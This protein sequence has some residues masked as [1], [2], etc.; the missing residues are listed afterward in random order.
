[1]EG[2]YRCNSCDTNFSSRS[3][4]TG[5]LDAVHL[6]DS[7]D[8]FLCNKRISSKNNLSRHLKEVSGMGTTN[9]IIYMGGLIQDNIHV[10]AR[11][12]T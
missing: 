5:H 6:N 7:G 9:R 2:C 11:K 3:A 4:L 8:C 10:W 1:M 12:T